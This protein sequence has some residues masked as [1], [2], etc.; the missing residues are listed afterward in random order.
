MV[1]QCGAGYENN[2]HEKRELKDSAELTD[3]N[4]SDMTWERVS[5]IGHA[6]R[7]EASCQC[8]GS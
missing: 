2:K 6:R 8:N 4:V 5:K 7:V 3:L 1:A